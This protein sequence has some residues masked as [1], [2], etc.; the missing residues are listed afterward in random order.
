MSNSMGFFSGAAGGLAAWVFD[1]YTW[2]PTWV[3][4]IKTISLNIPYFPEPEK[5]IASLIAA[6][7]CS[8]LGFYIQKLL[9]KIHGDK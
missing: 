6:T 3:L 7:A 4:N 5:L 1:A 2:L 9:K 8:V